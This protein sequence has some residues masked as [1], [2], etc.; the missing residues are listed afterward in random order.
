[1]FL[2]LGICPHGA[3]ALRAAKMAEG[4]AP[5][6]PARVTRPVNVV[7]AAHRSGK[8]DYE[9]F[10]GAEL[11]KKHKDKSYR[12]FNNINR[13]AKQFPQAHLETPDK[14]VTAWCSNDYVGDC[15]WLFSRELF[16]TMFAVGHGT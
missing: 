4:M 11:E 12:Y 10:Y 15:W 9:G 6:A 2:N 3:A 16:L 8:F 14:L 1:L 5:R 7:P 13:L